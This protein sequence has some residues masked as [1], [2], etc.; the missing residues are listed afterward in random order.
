MNR[1]ESVS[2]APAGNVDP[3]RRNRALANHWTPSY[4]SRAAVRSRSNGIGSPSAARTVNRSIGAG[5]SN[6]SR[7]ATSG[8]RLILNV[9]PVP[10]WPP[11]RSNRVEPSTTGSSAAAVT[12]S[13]A[14]PTT[15]GSPSSRPVFG[16]PRISDC[17]PQR[18]PELQFCPF[19][20]PVG[21]ARSRTTTRRSRET[22]A[23]C[24]TGTPGCSPEQEPGA[25]TTTSAEERGAE[26]AVARAEHGGR[27]RCGEGKRHRQDQQV[28]L[29]IGGRRSRSASERGRSTGHRRLPPTQTGRGTRTMSTP[30]TADTPHR[31][32][33]P[34]RTG[35]RPTRADDAIG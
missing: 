16:P 17:Y 5:S 27:D 10:A 11:S 12:A 6:C 33:T 2:W 18:I 31:A 22:R 14:T 35:P 19:W 25:R 3:V 29:H 7:T 8:L 32:R 4:S 24:A 15:T 30:G 28:A 23:W 21:F 9:Q 34:R 26:R 13:S 1:V 20:S